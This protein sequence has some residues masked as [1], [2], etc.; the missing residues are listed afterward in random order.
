MQKTLVKVM[1]PKMVSVKVESSVIEIAE[2][3]H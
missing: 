3:V 2:S 1:H